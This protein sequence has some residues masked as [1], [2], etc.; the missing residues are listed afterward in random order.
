LR[1]KVWLRWENPLREKG[2]RAENQGKR[3]MGKSYKTIPVD[4]K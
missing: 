1:I 4:K 3:K 2:I